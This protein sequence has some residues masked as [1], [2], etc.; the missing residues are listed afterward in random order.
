MSQT[1]RA[2]MQSA[3]LAIGAVTGPAVTAQPPPRPSLPGAPP[4]GPRPAPATP[5]GPPTPASSVQ[6]PKM[7]FGN[8]EISRLIVGCN[9]F[10][11]FAHYNRT[12]GAV[13]SEYYTAERVCDVLHQC[14][15]FGI[16]TYNYVDLGR[17]GQD[18]DRFIAEGGQMHLIVQGIGDP[19]PLY[20]LRK[21]LAMYHHGE[22]TDRA[23][24]DGQMPSVREW[25]K[26]AR[27]LGCLVGVGTH[28][29]EVIALVEE[30][31][32]DVDFYA[33]CVYNR[34][35]TADEWKKV[36]NGES[37]E[38]PGEIYLKSDPPRMYAVMRQTS[39][40]CFAFKVMAAGRID[41]RGAD[42]AFELAFASIKATDGVFVGMFPRVKDEVREDAERVCRIL[43][44]R[45]PALQPRAS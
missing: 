4:A 37:L 17:A 2:F 32:W 19:A 9:P 24:Q 39:K 35:R 22:R 40:A 12:L 38:M 21:P 42:E 15:R 29:P 34:T 14:A 25:C 45:S 18:L 20:A 7:R 36:L 1:R 11:G 6:V 27:D 43:R 26:Q 31:G 8:A 13:M 3:S 5:A 33:G 44:D 23:F 30:Q 41:D 10:Y 28:K 16:N